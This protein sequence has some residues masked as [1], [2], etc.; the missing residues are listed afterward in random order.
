[1]SASDIDAGAGR[2]GR[3][4]LL[5]PAVAVLAFL[6]A[7]GGAFYATYAGYVFPGERSLDASTAPAQ[8]DGAAAPLVPPLPDDDI[9]F[10]QLDP[11][12]VT[13]GDGRQLRFAAQLEVLP[14]NR[15]AVARLGPRIVDVMNNYLRAVDPSD[16]DRRDALLRLRGQ[17]LRRL[18]LVVGKGRIAD[19]LVM[20]FVIN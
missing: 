20:E 8:E 12:V 5:F 10:V 18:D 13:L 19:L 14:Q 11:L 17:L 1:M 15:A 3:R 2:D 9:A 4:G 6:L 16:L 7:G